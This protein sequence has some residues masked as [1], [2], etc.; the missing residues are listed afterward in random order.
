MYPTSVGPFAVCEPRP[1]EPAEA[2]RSE[3]KPIREARLEIFG[4]RNSSVR[5]N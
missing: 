3:G 1:A 2:Q 5:R 4:E